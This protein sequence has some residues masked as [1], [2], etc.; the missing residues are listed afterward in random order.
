MT[1]VELVGMQSTTTVATSVMVSDDH[2]SDNDH[3]SDASFITLSEKTKSVMAV[4]LI[5][6]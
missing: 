6:Q 5:A 2:I 1:G 3:I 4:S